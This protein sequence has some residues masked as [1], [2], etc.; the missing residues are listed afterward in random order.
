[1]YSRPTDRGRMSGAVARGRVGT[2]RSLIPDALLVGP[3]LALF[4][5]L[6]LAPVVFLLR[7]S[8]AGFD[9]ASGVLP[10]WTLSQ[11]FRALGDTYYFGIFARTVAISLA[12]TLA[13]ALLG[14]PVAYFI[15]FSRSGFRIWL[16][17]ILLVPLVTSAIVV[18]YG[19][20]VLMGNNGLIVSALGALGLPPPKLLY[21]ELG[22]AIGLTQVM[23]SFMVLATAASLQRVKASHLRA[24]RSLGAGPWQVFRR[25]VLPL[26]LPGVNTGAFLVFSLSMSAYATPVLLGGPQTKVVA[27][28]IYQQSISLLNLP[29]GAALAIL[30]VAST[31]GILGLRSGWGLLRARGSERPWTDR[32]VAEPPSQTH[33]EA[34]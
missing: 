9:Q 23:L 12:V 19:W 27:Y 32:A 17:V 25:I 3:P 20:F 13:C 28:L 8:L 33:G 1:M 18:S 6:Y 22:I 11:F 2:H 15:A 30:L 26:S 29:F 34:V 16:V 31:S 4:A 5:V 10:T 24:A 7:S 14:Y 21:T